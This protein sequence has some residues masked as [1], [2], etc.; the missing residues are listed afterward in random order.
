MADHSLPAL[1]TPYALFLSSLS[2][3]IKDAM[4][5]NDPT[6]V[7]V[8]NQPTNT[9]RWNSASKL[10]EKY[11]GTTWVALATLYAIAISGN[12]ATATTA[13]AVPWSGITA[14]PTTLAGFGISDAAPLASPLL[15]GTPK[16]NG[17]EIGYK[18]IPG[19]ASQATATIGARGECFAQTGGITIPANIFGV[20]DCFSIYNDTAGNITITQ[21]AALT[22][23]LVGTASTG[24]RT[25]ALRGWCTVWFRSTTEAVISGGGLS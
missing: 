18:I 3:R 16:T 10:W 1:T 8:T 23:R 14:K 17:I 24:N 6:N 9:V 25:L 20:G 19:I 7:T 5:G 11:N 21:G 4:L 2:D 13:A 12:A 15:T 22:L